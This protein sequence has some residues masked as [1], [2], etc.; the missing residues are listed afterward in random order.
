M[1]HPTFIPLPDY[2]EYAAD[3]MRRRAA[4]FYADIRRRRTVREF[5][6][7]PVPRDVIENCLRAAGTAPS[8]ANMQP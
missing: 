4:A 8:G 1:A 3:D 5:A 6:K 2:H 7:R